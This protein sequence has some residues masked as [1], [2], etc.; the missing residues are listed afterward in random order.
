MQNLKP[1][2]PPEAPDSDSTW[3]RAREKRKTKRTTRDREE[4][5]E[6]RGAFCFPFLA[7]TRAYSVGTG[8]PACTD[9]PVPYAHPPQLGEERFPGFWRFWG[10]N[11]GTVRAVSI[12]STFGQ[13]IFLAQTPVSSRRLNTEE[14]QNEFFPGHC[15]VS[16]A[17]SA[18]ASTPVQGPLGD[19]ENT[20]NSV[21][22]MNRVF[23]LFFIPP[24][25]LE[26]L[27]R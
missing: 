21:H 15:S 18:H 9:W 3:P 1:R 6:V 4:Q 10:T 14:N 13:K 23:G 27:P 12:R 26:L 8:A 24:W 11:A 2:T 25:G 16:T 22:L 7:C 17:P 20:E 5:L 19:E